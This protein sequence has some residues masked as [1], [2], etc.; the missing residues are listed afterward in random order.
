MP[1][2]KRT[3]V[4]A[5]LI[6][7]IVAATPM[8]ASGQTAPLPEGIIQPGVSISGLD[9]SGLSTQDAKSKVLNDL[10]A[11]RRAPLAL[12][13]RGQALQIDPDA[14]GYKAG[15][16][17]AVIAALQ[18][19]PVPGTPLDVPLEESITTSKLKDVLSWR[20][21]EDAVPARNAT[22][23]LGR[24]FRP[25]VTKAKVG[26]AIDI[27]KSV[28]LLGPAFVTARPV[29]PYALPEK[30]VAPQTTSVGNVVVIVRREFKLRL[31]RGETRIRTYP[32]AVG[33][34]AYPT[35]T[36]N[37]AVIVKQ[38]HP[39]W[40]PPD[41][42]WAAGLG[43]VPPGVGNPLGTRWIGTS[44]PAIGM[45]GTP[46]ASSI[47]TAASHGCIRMYMADVENLY[48]RVQIGTPVFIR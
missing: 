43:P 9:V 22:V 20:A 42:P 26:Y 4:R 31:Y 10:V 19:V 12:T 41:S 11:G 14:V 18:A 23:R 17:A 32:I 48:P 25:V 13:F 30:T 45:H 27:P 7:I 33:Q 1:R 6:G 37:Y 34:P 39:T 2:M 35:P 36:G 8:A 29:T 24:D 5:A 28:A 40:F 3:L 47:G 38:M 16:D 21:R 46:V 15:V 44:A